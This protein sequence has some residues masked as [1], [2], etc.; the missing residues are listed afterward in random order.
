MES[1]RWSRGS[2]TTCRP[3]GIACDGAEVM[4]SSSRIGA[5][6]TNGETAGTRRWSSPRHHRRARE[7]KKQGASRKRYAGRA[8]GFL[9]WVHVDSKKMEGKF[10]QPLDR[11]EV[12]QDVNESLV[13]ELH[14]R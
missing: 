1:C 8:T 6:A 11:D 13:V 3:D 9:A 2:T 12:A 10:K 4:S 5:I 14:P 7:S